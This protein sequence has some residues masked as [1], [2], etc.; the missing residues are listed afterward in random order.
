MR[1][2]PFSHSG[3]RWLWA[4]Q[5]VS[6]IGDQLF[7]MVMVRLTLTRPDP[8]FSL[9]VVFGSRFLALALLIVVGGVLADRLD[10]LRLMISS[11][12]IRIGAV[13]LLI[14]I[15]TS[16]PIWSLALITFLLGAGEA[17]FQPAID[18]VVPVIVP[19]KNLTQANAATTMLKNI[20]QG[21]GPGAAGLLVALIGPTTALWVDAATFAASICTLFFVR[22]SLTGKSTRSEHD[23]SSMLADAV[24]GIKVV[25]RMRW[26]M[27]LEVMAVLHV[28]LVVGPWFILVPVIAEDRLGGTVGYGLVLSSFALGGLTGAAIAGW[29]QKRLRLPGLWALGALAFFGVACLAFTVTTSTV[30]LAGLFAIAGAGVQFFDVIKTTAIQLHVPGNLLGRVFALDFFASFVTMPAGQM[31]AGLFIANASQ[32]VTVMSVGGLIVFVTTLLPLF[33][34]GVASMGGNPTLVKAAR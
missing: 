30:V 29:L 6:I 20:G 26:L 13:L 24:A 32:A 2:G 23:G 22:R 19:K 16:A 7:P 12:V 17:L 4:G 8:V 25:G 21:V 18:S 9:G 15:G 14:S 11:D 34:R 27:A 1:F 33:V 31:L 3:Y 10:K 28:L 5:L